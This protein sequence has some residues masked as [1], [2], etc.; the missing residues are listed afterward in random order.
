MSNTSEWG[1][2]DLNCAA[3]FGRLI[4][5]SRKRKIWLGPKDKQTAAAA[6]AIDDDSEKPTPNK[7][8]RR[9]NMQQDKDKQIATETTTDAQPIN[10][11][12]PL[13]LSAT[14]KN[15]WDP[16]LLKVSYND[17]Y[18]TLSDEKQLLSS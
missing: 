1:K 16:E 2:I 7:I 11:F 9:E 3:D 10:S 14:E 18:E 5:C 6:A 4:D 17:L 12:Q 13:F 15:N 8:P